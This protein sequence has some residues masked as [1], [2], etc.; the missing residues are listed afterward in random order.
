MIVFNL[1]ALAEAIVAVALLF[2]ARE[3]LPDTDFT[4]LVMMALP[5][6]VTAGSEW[7]GARGRV[8]WLPTVWFAGLIFGLGLSEFLGGFGA[9]LGLAAGIAVYIAARKRRQN[10]ALSP[11]DALLIARNAIDAGNV[12]DAWAALEH[13]FIEGDAPLPSQ[14]SH[15]RH[16]LAQLFRLIPPQHHTVMR[17]HFGRL[18]AAY[19]TVEAGGTDRETLSMSSS[20]TS[21]IEARGNM[22]TSVEVRDVPAV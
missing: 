2:G 8:F 14:A 18:D 9:F 11:Q 6:A 16:V 19:A 12:D 7:I 1:I 3:V 20:I 5:F 13:A 21:I 10:E 4:L 17:L 15:N 22:K